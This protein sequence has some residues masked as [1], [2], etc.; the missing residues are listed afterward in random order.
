MSPKKKMGRP[1]D[2]PKELSIRIRISA[3]DDRKLKYCS[4]ILGKPM[5]EIVRLGINEIYNHL[6]ETKK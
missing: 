4:A 1:T 2:D 6:E 5:S 3:E